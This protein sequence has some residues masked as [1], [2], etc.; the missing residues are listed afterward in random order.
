MDGRRI[1]LGDNRS[2]SYGDTRRLAVTLR[3]FLSSAMLQH[4]GPVRPAI[5]HLEELA[6]CDRNRLARHNKTNRS[7]PC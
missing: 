5:M 4:R 2:G 1:P 3:A 6:L 7:R